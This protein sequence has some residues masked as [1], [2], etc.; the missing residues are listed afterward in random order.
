MK[1]KTKITIE[2]IVIV[3][4]VV[5]AILIFFPLRKPK[6]DSETGLLP[7]IYLRYQVK[8]DVG[9][10]IEVVG[11]VQA[12]TKSV[13]PKVAGEIKE[14]YVEKG[15]HVEAG[16][17][18]AKIDDLQ[19][20]VQYL[21]ALNDYE[22]SSN[23]GER[24]K[25][26]KKLQLDLAEKN[27]GYTNI[28]APVSGV[29]S[30]VN[31]TEKDVVGTATA[32]FT[33]VEDNNLKVKVAIDEIDIPLIREGMEATIIFDSLNLKLPGKISWISPTATTDMGIVVI[34][35]EIE[36]EEDVNQYSI[37]LGMTADVEIVTLKLEGT[38][39]V[40]K[41]A[42]QEGPDGVKLVYKLTSEGGME[43][44]QVQT[45]RETDKM[46][47]ITSGLSKEDVV[48]IIPSSQ[49]ASRLMQQYGLT[50][51]IPSITPTTPSRVP[52]TGGGRGGF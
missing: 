8:S 23:L 7:S 44:V 26:V 47:E 48:L 49:E 13:M 17:L 46:V 36:F 37:I 50:I 52:P 21:S 1:K 27:L 43:P 32:A 35:I 30:E 29:I 2:S 4:I 34:P 14:I 3:A 15:D 33:I 18:L 24:M 41:D 9:D 10:S 19:Y 5:M 6:E 42:I 11:T 31:V 28:T 38:V 12:S 25:Q 51:S 39:A 40:P 16:Q 20:Q 45:G 22:A